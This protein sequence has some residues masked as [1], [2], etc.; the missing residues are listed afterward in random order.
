M[1]RRL[2]PRALCRR[3]LLLFARELT[4]PQDLDL[5]AHAALA[6]MQVPRPA[7]ERVRRNACP[8]CGGPPTFIYKR[9]CRRCCPDH[10]RDLPVHLIREVE[11]ALTLAGRPL[12]PLVRWV[13][14]D[15]AN[16]ARAGREQ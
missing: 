10:L 9:L 8:V 16:Q 15:Y 4:R 5:V 13:G 1:A 7:E 12:L 14:R 6:L 3:R 2:D 11:Q